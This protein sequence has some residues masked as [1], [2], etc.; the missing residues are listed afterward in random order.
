MSAQCLLRAARCAPSARHASLMPPQCRGY[1]ARYATRVSLLPERAA[2]R[3][4]PPSERLCRRAV[5][6]G[7]CRAHARVYMRRQQR[8]AVHA[9]PQI[10]SARTK[11]TP[12][13]PRCGGGKTTTMERRGMRDVESS[14]HGVGQAVPERARWRRVGVKREN[15]RCQQ[16][17]L[18]CRALVWCNGVQARARA[19]YSRK[20]R[21]FTVAVVVVV[22]GWW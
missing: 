12:S 11:E 2:R 5:K 19:R 14:E 8:V 18:R 4:D 15:G 10:G 13:P 7:V 20:G 21:S 6:G 1:A 9:T 22:V 16:R 17:C 3:H